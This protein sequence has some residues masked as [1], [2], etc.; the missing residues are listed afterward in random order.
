RYNIFPFAMLE[1]LFQ[2]DFN[3]NN[4]WIFIDRPLSA[5]DNA[6]HLY[7]YI[8]QNHPEQNI[9]FALKRDSTDWDRL[10]KEGFNLIDFGSFTFEKIVKKVSKVISSHCD[11]YLMKYIG[12]NQQFIF[13]QHGITQ[14]DIS[15]WLNQIKIDLLIVSTRDEYNSI[16]NDYTHYKFGKKEVALI[17]LARHDILLKNN[18]VNAKQILIMP[19]W[20]MNLIISSIDLGLMEMKKKIKQSKYFH[21]WNSLLNNGLLAKLCEKYGYA[22]IFNPHP[23]IIPYLDNFNMPSYIKTIGKTESLQKLFCNSS[24]L[25]TDY[26]SVAFE[27]A[28]LKKPV[29]YYQFDKDDF[30]S[31]HTLNNGY[32]N[33]QD[34]GFGPVANSEQELLLELEKLFRTNFFLS[35]IY[36]NNIEK[37]FSEYHGNNC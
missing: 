25:I 20:R 34:N 6:E 27:M 18:K 8:M 37:I 33:Y 36:K 24:L 21:K 22:I 29:I 13:L 35:D 11:E 9:V 7:R 26:S 10:K 32:F 28:Y 12:I 4:C 16:V 2:C 3:S 14:N 30:F 17:G 31:S 15:R 1:D 23:N 5:N 19:T